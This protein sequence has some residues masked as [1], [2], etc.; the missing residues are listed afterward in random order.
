[1]STSKKQVHQELYP[2][3]L[4][5]KEKIQLPS[6]KTSA[7]NSRN[8]SITKHSKTNKLIK[9]SN[10]SNP[11]KSRS[12]SREKIRKHPSPHLLSKIKK[13]RIHTL[14]KYNPKPSTYNSKV[15]NDIIHDERK[16]IV[17]IFKNLLF[18]DETSDF[19]KRFYFL[20]ESIN[21]L[22]QIASYYETYTLFAPVYFAF[23]DII[24]IMNKNTKRKRRY[25]E[26][27]E[28]NEDRVYN[29]MKN[30]KNKSN[31]KDKNI[32]YII[33]PNEIKEISSLVS[34]K[35]KT[36]NNNI[37]NNSNIERS[38][39]GSSKS[40]YSNYITEFNVLMNYNFKHSNTSESIMNTLVNDNNFLKESR[41][42]F[43]VSNEAISFVRD[44]EH[45]NKASV[46]KKANADTINTNSIGTSLKPNTNS[47]TS[48]NKAIEIKK[49]DLKNINFLTQKANNNYTNTYN[50]KTKGQSINSNNPLKYYTIPTT[51][52]M[53]SHTQRDNKNL[54]SLVKM[55]NNNSQPKKTSLTKH[56]P[57]NQQIKFQ[58]IESLL[59]IIH[60]QQPY[61]TNFN[62]CNC[63]SSHN[64]SSSSKTYNKLKYPNKK[65]ANT[66]SGNT[67][68]TKIKNNLVIQTKQFTKKNNNNNSN[69]RDNS[70]HN[71]N[72]NNN[73]NYSAIKKINN[74]NNSSA[75][76]SKAKYPNK[77]SITSPSSIIN[78]NVIV[79]SSI[80]NINLN[81]NLEQHPSSGS[82]SIHN[83]MNNNIH[84]H[85]SSTKKTSSIT[86]SLNKKKPNKLLQC[87]KNMNNPPSNAMMLQNNSVNK[88]N[89]GIGS[90]V[91]QK[92]TK[93]LNSKLKEN[94]ISYDLN[95]NNVHISIHK[96]TGSNSHNQ[97][98]N[99]NNNNNM[100]S[101]QNVS[102]NQNS[103][104]HSVNIN[105]NCG[106]AS[107][108][109]NGVNEKKM[110]RNENVSNNTHSSGN[111]SGNK[112]KQGNPNNTN[113][114]LSVHT[115][116]GR[117][118]VIPVVSGCET[119]KTKSK[120]QFKKIANGINGNKDDSTSLIKIRKK[121]T[122]DKG[123]KKYPLT[124]RNEK[125]R[126]PFEL[127][128]KII[129]KS[130]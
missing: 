39:K 20:F 106:S 130:K 91:N 111:K 107:L 56:Q 6:S 78:N 112:S 29:D 42:L 5:L 54:T 94:K 31:V 129:K 2:M 60:R 63:S 96:Q 24:K 128:N 55:N 36:N 109:N 69:P 19:L 108:H 52:V 38:R 12:K 118:M 10:N 81:L 32:K 28:E 116:K 75:S 62:S 13:F 121:L 103:K 48:N 43:D 30:G 73:G 82:S 113:N 115:N 117:H 41:T 101:N 70:L 76:S 67:T 125:E 15:I 85:P 66:H 59:K 114:T 58:T 71:S 93:S 51:T 64:N 126:I 17:C 23:E 99:N 119:K 18:W 95:V 50:S 40:F 44:N 26:M 46:T 100:V 97:I 3:Q 104:Q 45:N 47:T 127:L 1:M 102:Q 92:S 84:S 74:S 22:P 21:R 79:P 35:N 89:L 90:K 25:L 110:S 123:D 33:S 11:K 68:A 49:L 105:I 27:V 8:Q 4:L 57:P 16:H 72:R 14:T 9:H 53:K 88:Q 61:T 7:L 83:N 77:I 80:Y 122:N 124:S 87:V 120:Q 37:N 65:E 86:T 34:Y 98:S